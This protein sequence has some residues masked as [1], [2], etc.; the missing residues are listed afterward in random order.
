MKPKWKRAESRIAASLLETA[1]P[2]EQ[3]AEAAV[4][5]LAEEKF[6]ILP[7]PAVR[8]YY[9]M[10]AGDTDRWLHGMNRMQQRIEE[11]GL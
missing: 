11:A 1:I 10:R 6:L 3:V 9:G 2:P 7:H 5:G 8:D 4:K